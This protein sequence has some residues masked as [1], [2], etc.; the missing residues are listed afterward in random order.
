[1][2]FTRRAEGKTTLTP[3]LQVRCIAP[4]DRPGISPVVDGAKPAATPCT[5]DETGKQGAPAA[6][7][8]RNT[9]LAVGIAGEHRLITLTLC[10][11]P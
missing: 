11:A 9:T 6:A 3:Q 7:G 5:T 10:P 1:M 8:L 4:I 2:P